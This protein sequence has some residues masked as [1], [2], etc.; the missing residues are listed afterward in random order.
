MLAATY[1]RFGA[2][3]PRNERRAAPSCS[4]LIPSLRYAQPQTLTPPSLLAACR[5]SA[6][7]R[8]RQQTAGRSPTAA[9]SSDTPP[10]R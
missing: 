9:S 2:S 7:P 1:T 10:R 5:S 3:P 8:A 4:M 6:S